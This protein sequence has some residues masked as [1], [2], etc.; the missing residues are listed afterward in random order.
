MH[1]MPFER[2]PVISKGEVTL[3]LEIHDGIKE[4]E[5]RVKNVCVEGTLVVWALGGCP[6][7]GLLVEE[8]F[9]PQPE[10]V[11]NFHNHDNVVCSNTAITIVTALSD[12]H[13]S[14]NL[15]INTSIMS[16]VPKLP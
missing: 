11:G 16:A 12:Q 9:S 3:Y 13:P 1:C 5:N 15:S 8:V 10:K 4:L 7:L 2:Q 14:Q 6:L